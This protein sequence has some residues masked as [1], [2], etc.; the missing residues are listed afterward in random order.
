M[1]RFLV[2]E[3]LPRSLVQ[4]FEDAG[5][6]AEHVGDVG[7][8]GHSDRNVLDGAI[9]RGAAL[10]SADIGFA[11]LLAFP[12][13]SHHGIVVARFPNEVGNPVLNRSI[14]DALLEL[15]ADD[16][17]GSLVIIEPTRIRIRR[18]GPER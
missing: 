7:L 1:I 16:L 8:R 15:R 5:F 18:S 10:V 3:D 4:A 11:N 2:D 17:T 12:L 9:T 13:G 14:V 6:V